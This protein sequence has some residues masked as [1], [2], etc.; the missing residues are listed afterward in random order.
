MNNK[1]CQLFIIGFLFIT[2]QL[3]NGKPTCGIDCEK[4]H[5]D[6]NNDAIE[7]TKPIPKSTRKLLN[8][9]IFRKRKS[10]TND[11]SMESS[12][13]YQYIPI[14]RSIDD[15]RYDAI[16]FI[17]FPHSF[18][19]TIPHQLIPN[20]IIDLREN[21]C[22]DFDIFDHEQTKL[23]SSFNRH[24]QQKRRHYRLI[25]SIGIRFNYTNQNVKC[26]IDTL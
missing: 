18:T 26:R 2:I 10:L 17:L 7:L 13:R 21:Q 8:N 12:I 5:S 3:I 11:R 15:H 19:T 9:L 20:W 4:L 6:G 14:D 25:N 16:V 23:F 1:N 22:L 24:F